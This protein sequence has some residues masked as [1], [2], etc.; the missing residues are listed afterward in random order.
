VGSFSSYT[1]TGVQ[2]ND[3]GGYYVTVANSF[4]A[5]DSR[6]AIL[7]VTPTPSAASLK[8]VKGIEPGPT[9]PIALSHVRLQ[10]QHFQFAFPSSTGVTYEVQYKENLTDSEWISLMTNSGTGDW[11]TNVLTTNGASGFFRVL[12]K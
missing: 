12:T 7:T 3:A 11:L 8:S 2:T 9:N 10:A 6:T 4:G 5:V 1:K